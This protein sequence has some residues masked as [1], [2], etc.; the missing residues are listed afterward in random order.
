MVIPKNGVGAS[1]NMRNFSEV[2][3]GCSP[4]VL[5]TMMRRVAFNEKF[6][7][8]CSGLDIDSDDR[9]VGPEINYVPRCLIL[10]RFAFWTNTP[11]GSLASRSFQFQRELQELFWNNAFSVH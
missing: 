7:A 11:N 4:E 9:S 3:M 10:S 1:Q 5:Y 2:K 6:E 8:R